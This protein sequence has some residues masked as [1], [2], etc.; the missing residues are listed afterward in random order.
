MEDRGRNGLPDGTVV[1]VLLPSVFVEVVLVDLK[2][3]PGP[4]VS[5]VK[6]KVRVVAQL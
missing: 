4:V 6:D 1:D 3:E 2:Q 5:H